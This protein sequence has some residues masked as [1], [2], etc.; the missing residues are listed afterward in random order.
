[1]F[2]SL[3][4]N[5]D[6]VL[7][8]DEFV[9]GICRVIE[10]A[11]DN[12]LFFSK[13]ILEEIFQTADVD[14]QGT[15]TYKQFLQ[16]FKVEFKRR[17]VRYFAKQ[18]NMLAKKKTIARRKES[19]SLIDRN[20]IT[21]SR[22]NSRADLSSL[23]GL[24]TT[25][26]E[27]ENKVNEYKK[28]NDELNQK[29]AENVEKMATVEEEKKVSIEKTS[30]LEG[31]ITE[32]E[33]NILHEQQQVQN[34]IT[35]MEEDKEANEQAALGAA[36]LS[37]DAQLVKLV[38]GV[39]R[40]IE[41]LNSLGFRV[42]NIGG[43]RS[44]SRENTAGEFRR[45]LE[46]LNSSCKFVFNCLRTRYPGL[47]I[48]KENK[49]KNYTSS[50]LPQ[51]VISGLDSGVGKDGNDYFMNENS[52]YQSDAGGVYDSS[53][54]GFIDGIHR[55][56]PA[57]IRGHLDTLNS[58]EIDSSVYENNLTRT[59]TPT[60]SQYTQPE[61]KFQQSSVSKSPQKFVMQTLRRNMPSSLKM[62]T[63]KRRQRNTNNKNRRRRPNT[64]AN[65]QLSYPMGMEKRAWSSQASLSSN[66]TS[67]FGRGNNSNNKSSPNLFVGFHPSSESAS[68]LLSAV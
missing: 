63:S 66:S 39:L 2:T 27:L 51:L 29:Y 7:T 64:V 17:E 50:N 43:K 38:H 55:K 48:F 67:S 46:D 68:E 8:L 53:R 28:Q 47:Q 41:D 49:N 36:N 14:K 12:E 35:K 3:D 9:N 10:G 23:N 56:Q 20:D 16:N 25:I 5:N 24:Q 62:K 31:I 11:H 44:V 58:S 21:N 34:L 30:E 32:L 15:L 45:R 33:R 57:W 37:L 60:S 1:M 40:R 59:I 65:S 18:L 52:I 61:S 6:S 4:E 13:E 22:P 19:T 26:S 54:K 42:L